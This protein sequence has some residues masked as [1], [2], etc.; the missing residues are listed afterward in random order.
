MNSPIRAP[1]PGSALPIALCLSCF[2]LAI[3]AP[4]QQ[5]D[6]EHG[7]HGNFV[8]GIDQKVGSA[9][10]APAQRTAALALASKARDILVR[11]SAVASP[12]GY[13]VR[14]NRV[15]G[16]ITDWVNFDSG[17]SFYT[18][19][20]AAF[21]AA[22][23]KPSPTDFG[24][25]DFGVYLN[26]VIA[27]PLS[28]F[29]PPA[30]SAPWVVNGNLPV[31]EGGRRTGEIH[32]FPVYDG[33][34]AILGRSNQPAFIPLTREQFI[35]LQIALY[36]ERQANMHKQ[37]AGQPL[38]GPMGDAFASVEKDLDEA[39]A[40]QQNKLASM[41]PSDRAAPAAVLTGY[42]TADL[43]DINDDGAVPL[44]IP[45]PAFFDRSLPPSVIQ[46]VAVYIPFLNGAPRAEGLPSG[47]SE[48]WMPAGAKIRDQLDWSAL[49]A[50]VRQQ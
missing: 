49:A 21:F 6:T 45:N 13:S 3:P 18:G 26:T 17:L 12:I 40:N 9:S 50:L 34:C 7:P 11:D 14:V 41:S 22:G 30:A 37:L 27:C 15:Y 31:V 46:S 47:L 48:D 29:S 25:M 32:G 44:S 42:G 1:K 36:K 28:D 8:L 4:A 24:Q 2:A 33:Q 35:Q 38:S 16:R 10:L 43:T 23:E 20:S 39:I 5:I 19:A